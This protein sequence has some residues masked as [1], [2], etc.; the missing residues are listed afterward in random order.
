MSTCP[1]CGQD[2]DDGELRSDLLRALALIEAN[3][4]GDVV[5]RTALAPTTT[6]EMV[7]MIGTLSGIARSLISGFARETHQTFDDV[8]AGM[9]TTAIGPQ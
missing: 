8:I 1:G 2:H 9:R 7:A 5:A 6:H 4:R 3:E